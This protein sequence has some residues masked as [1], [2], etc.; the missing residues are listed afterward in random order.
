M[1]IIDHVNIPVADL[2][3]ARRFYEAVLAPLGYRPIAQDGRAFGFGRSNWNFGVV[4]TP[5]PFPTLHL[6]FV[7]HSPEQVDEFFEVALRAGAQS[8]GEPGL[9][10]LYHPGYYAAFVLDPDGHNVEA[11][12]RGR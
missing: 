4:E 2:D 9:R 10:D 1:S 11:V 8:N 7:A 12:Y 3:R 5:P 6:A